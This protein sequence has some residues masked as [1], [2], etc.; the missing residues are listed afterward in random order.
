MLLRVYLSISVY[1]E[2]F[3]DGERRIMLTHIR[4]C[5][6]HDG[7]DIKRRQEWGERS[8]RAREVSETIVHHE[9]DH[10]LRELK[11]STFFVLAC[12]EPPQRQPTDAL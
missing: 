2:L 3:V 5:K 1:R 9:I 4:N 12:S 10:R 8:S 7:T 6:M 11:A